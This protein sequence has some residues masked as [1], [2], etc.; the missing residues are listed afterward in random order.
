MV[1]LKMLITELIEDEPGQTGRRAARRAALLL[2]GKDELS[3]PVSTHVE[4]DFALRAS[5]SGIALDMPVWLVSCAR[6]RA[7]STYF[8]Q[9]RSTDWWRASG[10]RVPS[11]QLVDSLDFSSVTRPSD[12]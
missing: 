8:R 6:S 1:T 4:D 12:Q 11:T 10:A 7:L 9:P 2:T 5:L 3:S